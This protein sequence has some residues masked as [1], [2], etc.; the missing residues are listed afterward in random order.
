MGL[1]QPNVSVKR[2]VIQ[3]DYYGEEEAERKE[4]S[5]SQMSLWHE[6][7]SRKTTA[8]KAEEMGECRCNWVR[9]VNVAEIVLYTFEILGQY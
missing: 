2:G 3:K 4:L 6:N 7:Q 8:G 5:S 1:G 9:A